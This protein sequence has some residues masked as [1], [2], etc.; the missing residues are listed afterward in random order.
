[1]FVLTQLQFGVA[2]PAGWLKYKIL[3]ANTNK[4]KS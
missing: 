1:M 2:S 4:F 3:C